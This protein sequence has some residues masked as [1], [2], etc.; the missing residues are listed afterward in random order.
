LQVKAVTRKESVRA[1]LWLTIDELVEKRNNI[2][3][4]DLTV[5]ATYLDVQKY[6]KAVRTFTD[7]V[8]RHFGRVLGKLA[9]AAA[10]W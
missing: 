2:A 1:D 9:G 7:R 4:G 8:D 10:P 5:E 6:L 3:H